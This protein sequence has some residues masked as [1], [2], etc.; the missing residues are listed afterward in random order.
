MTA[1]FLQQVKKIK[2]GNDDDADL[3]KEGDADDVVSVEDIPTLAF[4]LA[5]VIVG[6]VYYVCQS[7]AQTKRLNAMDRAFAVDESSTLV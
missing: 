5:L 1:A 3:P 7:R 4:S 2:E 6:Y